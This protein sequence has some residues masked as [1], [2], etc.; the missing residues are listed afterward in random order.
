MSFYDSNIPDDE[1][2][3][4]PIE[5]DDTCRAIHSLIQ[6]K[7][8][9][10]DILIQNRTQG[11]ATI[12]RN[13]PIGFLYSFTSQENTTIEFPKSKLKPNWLNKVHLS[14]PLEYKSKYQAL[15][16]KFCDVFSQNEFNLGWTDTVKHSIQL[17]D[18]NAIFTKQFCIPF[19][20][21][22]SNQQFHRRHVE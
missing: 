8:G 14:A 15:F 9:K 18:D 19:A 20:H 5:D 2:I 10:S 3:C 6:V 4:F 1:Y 12:S 13:A 21:Q 17:K 7:D 16:Q 22:K 11:P